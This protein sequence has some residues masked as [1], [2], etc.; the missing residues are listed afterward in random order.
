[1]ARRRVL[2]RR[3]ELKGRFGFIL[4]AVVAADFDRLKFPRVSPWTILEIIEA[5][6]TR[7]AN[8]N[9]GKTLSWCLG[10]QIHETIQIIS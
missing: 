9:L 6:L 8:P 5:V 4:Q 1:L 3:A 10:R 2:P 7:A